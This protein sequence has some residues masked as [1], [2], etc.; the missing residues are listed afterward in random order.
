MSSTQV[1]T[2][3]TTAVQSSQSSGIYDPDV[4]LLA[5]TKGLMT[6][7]GIPIP[8]VDREAAIKFVFEILSLHEVHN[9]QRADLALDEYNHTREILRIQE[10]NCQ[11][12][13]ANVNKGLAISA[14]F[15]HALKGDPT[16]NTAISLKAPRGKNGSRTSKEPDDY[17]YKSNCLVD[18]IRD[19]PPAQGTSAL[20]HQPLPRLSA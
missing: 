14:Y 18:H 13:A 4:P 20:E 10:L 6:E 19:L 16:S 5:P 15:H 7:Q 12:E 11:R 2:L 1:T 3:V 9:R 8:M 17:V